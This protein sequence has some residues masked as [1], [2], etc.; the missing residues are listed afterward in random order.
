MTEDTEKPAEPSK[1]FRHDSLD[2][3]IKMICEAQPDPK[4]AI[5]GREAVTTVAKFLDQAIRRGVTVKEIVA[6]LGSFDLNLREATVRSYLAAA[7][8]AAEK[9][10]AG[11]E[12]EKAA[13]AAKAMTAGRALPHRDTAT[14]TGSAPHAPP[15]PVHERPSP[16]INGAT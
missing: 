1:K 12:K 11:K 7:K 9:K 8:A 15:A 2:E 3:L 13:R 4:R 6:I 10:K 5:T 16:D 14:S